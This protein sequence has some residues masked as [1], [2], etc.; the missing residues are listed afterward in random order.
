MVLRARQKFGKYRIKRK[1]A[2]GGFAVVYEAF[3]T[4]EGI[5]VAL[6]LP[7]GH[8]VTPTMLEDFR[9]EVRMVARLDHPHILPIK[10]AQ[11]IDGQF[12]IVHPLGIGTLDDRLAKRMSIET[13]FDLVDQMLD[14]LSHAHEHRVIHCDVKPENFILFDDNVL[15]LS[16]FGIARLGARTVVMSGAGTVGYVAPEQALGRASFRSDV[17]SMGLIL[18]ELF[19]GELPEWPYEWPGPG[20]KR[21]KQRCHPDFLAL[22]QRSIQVD[23]RKRFADAIELYAAFTR[24]SER[25]RLVAPGTRKRSKPK[26]GTDRSWRQLRKRQ[27]LKQYKRSLHIVDA[28]KRCDGPLSEAMAACPWCGVRRAKTPGRTT[29][30]ERCTRCKRGRNPDWRFCPYCYGPGFKVVSEREYKDATATARCANKACT[31]RTLAPFMRYCPWCQR[32]PKG[33]W[34]VPG[35]KHTCGKCHWGV[36]PGYWSFCAWCGTSL[37]QQRKG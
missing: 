6:K 11:F 31:R 34:K 22:I 7:H 8:L 32:K 24:L 30:R 4:I 3:D 9:K 37:P 10:N 21:L 2:D 27:F 17:F 35:S 1:L 16:D 23:Q 13:R 26:T 33:P 14:A 12:S 28:C 36:L 5:S 20:H 15:R 25:K 18:Y 19:A 29:R